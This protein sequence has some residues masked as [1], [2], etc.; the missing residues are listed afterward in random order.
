LSN[1]NVPVL[2]VID[3]ANVPITPDSVPEGVAAAQAFSIDS[4]LAECAAGS[5]GG[6]AHL[7]VGDDFLRQFVPPLP[8]P[9]SGMLYAS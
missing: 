8:K 1:D 9:G 4:V 3:S 6:L 2:L 5:V 7:T